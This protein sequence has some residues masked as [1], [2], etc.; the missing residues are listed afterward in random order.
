MWSFNFLYS[1]GKKQ[2]D[3]DY[4]TLEEIPPK[5]SC[6]ILIDWFKWG[7]SYPLIFTHSLCNIALLFIY[8]EFHNPTLLNIYSKN[9][10]NLMPIPRKPLFHIIPSP[11]VMS[12]VLTYPR[13]EHS[14]FFRGKAAADILFP[15]LKDL[16][17]EEIQDNDFLLTC[18][19]SDINTYRNTIFKLIG[20]A[21]SAWLQ[22]KFVEI[23][24][25]TMFFFTNERKRR[26][27]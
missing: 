13:N 9:K 25:D 15:L 11:V 3:P 4:V 6:D 18:F 7:I 20:P 17:N 12:P 1:L 22:K 14:G 19:K 5:T 8:K 24:T 2:P 16:F 21:N 23:I 26:C 27:C 10:I